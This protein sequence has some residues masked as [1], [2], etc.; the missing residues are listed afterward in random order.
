MSSFK[1][2]GIPTHACEHFYALRDKVCGE[3]GQQWSDALGALL[4]HADP[5]Q[6]KHLLTPVPQFGPEYPLFLM[7]AGAM[8]QFLPLREAGILYDNGLVDVKFGTFVLEE[9]L[10]IRLM[11]DEEKGKISE[12]ADRYS[13]NK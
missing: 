1:L 8:F 2:G 4:A 9:G 3:N 7:Q 11:T 12:I 5:V 13:E 10:K 6:A